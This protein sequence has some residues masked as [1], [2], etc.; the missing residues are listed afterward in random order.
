MV[1][2]SIARVADG[3]APGWGTYDFTPLLAPIEPWISDADLS[4]CQMEMTLSEQDSGFSYY[5]RFVVP[6]ELAEAVAAA[7][8]DACSTASNH[9]LDGGTAG[10]ARTIEL[11]RAAGVEPT[12]TAAVPED[13]LPDLFEVNG[14]TVG[15]LAYTY[16]TNQGSVPE[17]WMVNVIDADAILADAS[18]AREHGAEFVILGLHWG[19]EYRSDPTPAQTALADRL[20]ASPDIDVIL[21]HHVHVV[22]PID[23]LHGKYV[24]YGMSNLLSNIRT[25]AE[26]G[27]YGTEDGIVV[28]LR[29]VEGPDGHFDVSEL[30]FTP[31]WVHPDTKQVLPV[32]HTLRS[33][34]GPVGQLAAS[35]QRTVQRV[36]ALGVTEVEPTRDPWPAVSC[37]G[38]AATILGTPGDD[39]LIGTAGDDVIVARDG[40]DEVWGGDGDDLVCTGGGDDF[41]AGGTGMDRLFGGDGDDDL[42]GGGGADTVW[43]DG[44]DDRLWG[45]DGPDVLV[46]G[47]GDDDL[48]GGAGADYLWGGG[49]IDRLRGDGEDSCGDARPARCV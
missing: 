42:S 17:P 36:G 10:V 39:V 9:S 45:G 20:L 49:G 33:G 16:G 19:V 30:R 43:G 7:G 47:A 38:R 2:A 24:V 1:H 35:W 18:W 37:R 13:R 15:F 48:T 44:G 26:K 11:L 6:G 22:Q 14:V 12:G 3:H 31:V 28:H 34:A 4:I 29:V 8:F 41:A 27:R 21:G 5:P 23:R 40:D 25:S 32:G 46:G